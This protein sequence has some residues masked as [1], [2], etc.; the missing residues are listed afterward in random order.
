MSAPASPDAPRSRGTSVLIALVVMASI[1]MLLPAAVGFTLGEI[2]LARGFIYSASLLIALTSLIYLANRGRSGRPARAGGL[3][4]PFYLLSIIYLVLPLLMAVPVTEARADIRLLDAWFDMTASFTT[5]GAFVIDGD[6]PRSL[7]LWRAIVAW[8]GGL[9]VLV[10]ALALLAPLR[11]GG[12]DLVYL[13]PPDDEVSDTRALQAGLDGRKASRIDESYADQTLPRLI[14]AFGQLAPIY[15]GLTLLLWVGLSMLGTPPLKALMLAMAS[16]ST[17]G[18]AP[19]GLAV[20]VMGEALILVILCLAVSRRFWPSE[21]GPLRLGRLNHDPEIRAAMGIMAILILVLSLRLW[22]G[23]PDLG[24]VEFLAALWGIIFTGLSFLTTAG[25][26]SDSGQVTQS[27]FQGP[28]GMVLMGLC[29]IGGGVATTAG[30]IKLMRVFALGWQARFE[31][32]HLIFP[33]SVGGDGASLRQLRKQGAFSAWLM[34]MVLIFTL[35]TLTAIL[36]LTGLELESAMTYTVA[37][38]TTTGPLA[39]IAMTEPLAW[40]ALDDL[41]RMT[42]ALG[43]V[44]GRLELLLLLSVFWARFS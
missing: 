14:K 17:S 18:I 34:L 1:A 24:V 37:A 35:V 33:S 2:R 3:S 36:T 40:A 13:D 21:R 7:H 30:G 27:V 42:M 15:A 12:F 32:D 26:I 38:V 9:F 28:A 19:D 16:V 5:T 6:L 43:M 29:M 10:A 22:W 11:L 39:Q 44:L 4:H 20:G 41:G 23:K 8:G 25:F 31:L